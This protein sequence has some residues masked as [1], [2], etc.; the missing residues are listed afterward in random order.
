MH[1]EPY[2][3][4]LTLTSHLR[5]LLHCNL[6]RVGFL[7]KLNRCSHVVKLCRHCGR[8]RHSA[9]YVAHSVCQLYRYDRPATYSS[10]PLSSLGEVRRSQRLSV[11]PVRPTRYLLFSPAVVTRRG[12]SLT[13]SV[14][15]TGTTDPLLTLLARCR[16]SARYV[17]HSVCQLYRYDRPATYSSRPL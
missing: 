13:A 7:Q 5:Y 12:T 15:C 6:E 4:D 2:R 8:C 1:L 14:S 16:H 11:V 3:P 17:A 9:R 10:R